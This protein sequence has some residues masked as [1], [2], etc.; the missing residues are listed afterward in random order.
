L[1]A[2]GQSHC[3]VLEVHVGQRVE[4][5]RALLTPRTGS[6]GSACIKP[7]GLNRQPALNP[8]EQVWRGRLHT[9]AVLGSVEHSQAVGSCRTGA[10]VYNL[11]RQEAHWVRSLAEQ[12]YGAPGRPG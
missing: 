12:R 4:D 10:L 2:G 3:L 8:T 6:L 5:A 11:I 9:V 7:Q 1:Q